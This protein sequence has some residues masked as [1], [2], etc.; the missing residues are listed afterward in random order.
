MAW[1]PLFGQRQ[2]GSSSTRLS[3]DKVLNDPVS[4]N[5]AIGI[6]KPDD[7][8]LPKVLARLNLDQP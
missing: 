6:L 7:I 1:H 8:I 5:P 4:R 3:M 2:Y